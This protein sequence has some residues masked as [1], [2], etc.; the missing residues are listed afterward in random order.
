MHQPA[1]I[2]LK[3]LDEVG[4]K[5]LP[6]ADKPAMLKYIREVLEMRVGE[7]LASNLPEKLLEEFL[8]YVQRNES[9]QVLAWLEKNVPNHSE[10]VRM[11]IDKLRAEIKS[12]AAQ[13]LKES[14]SSD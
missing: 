8:T 10:V 14:Q 12:N 5:D 3:F 9:D 13:I 11:E 2:N 7:K 4:L 1:R 6:A